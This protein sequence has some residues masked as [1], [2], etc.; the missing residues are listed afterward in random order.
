MPKSTTKEEGEKQFSLRPV[1]LQ[2]IQNFNERHNAALVDFLSYLSID[3]L[4]YQPTEQ[5]RFRTDD[6]GVLYISELPKEVKE[7]VTV[8]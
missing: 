6:K 8:S 1:D 7:E 2:M 5:T 4:G 3:R